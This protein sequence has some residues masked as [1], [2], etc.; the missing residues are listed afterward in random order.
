MRFDCVACLITVVGTD[1]T[2]FRAYPNH[3]YSQELIYVYVHHTF[4]S[5]RPVPVWCAVYLL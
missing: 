3:E 5:H 1:S 2:T 4:T